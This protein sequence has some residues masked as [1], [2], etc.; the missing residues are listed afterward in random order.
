MSAMQAIDP[1]Y[2]NLISRFALMPIRTKSQ[3]KQATDLVDEL[4]DRLETLTKPE[5]AYF[6]V[7]CDLIKHYESENCRAIEKLS[8]VEA[9]GYLME[10]NR[11][12]LSD[13]VP[14][15]RHKS[16]LSA[17]LNGKRGLSKANALRLAEYF[18]VSAQIFLEVL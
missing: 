9:L 7:L 1:D 16:H 13:L 11:L 4:S 10:V 5:R 8:P 12:K 6:D 17:F 15:V 3:I 14:I 18:K 2:M